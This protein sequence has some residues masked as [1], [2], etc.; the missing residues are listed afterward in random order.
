[1]SHVKRRQEGKRPRIV[2]DSSKDDEVPDTPEDLVCFCGL[3]INDVP[4]AGPEYNLRVNTKW[5]DPKQKKLRNNF[6]N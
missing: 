6:K 1:M 5:L 4:S 2:D 3:A